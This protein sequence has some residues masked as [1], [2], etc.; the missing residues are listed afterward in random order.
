MS[1]EVCFASLWRYRRVRAGRLSPYI[2]H[3]VARL[4]Q[5]GYRRG[6]TQASISVVA[7]FGCWLER[8]QLRAYELDEGIVEQYY[9]YYR[10]HVSYVNLGAHA[11]LSGFLAMLREMDVCAPATPQA[12]VL[13][14]SAQMAEDFKRF[15]LQQR[16]LDPATVSLHMP[17]VRRF[18]QDRCGGD[19]L[20][21]ATLTGHD[22][23]D[24]IKDLAHEYVANGRTKFFVQQQCSSLRT[25]L[26]YLLFRGEITMD[27]ASCVPTVANRK[28]AALP[29]FLSPK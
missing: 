27:L 20:R 9:R 12:A 8:Q 29:K 21:L 16:G 19:A 7:G 22:I 23:T 3:F 13:T 28:L 24:F 14:P 2:D 4:I 26:R 5:Q 18:L 17:V 10:G 1:T 11:A 25:F 15:S 6:A